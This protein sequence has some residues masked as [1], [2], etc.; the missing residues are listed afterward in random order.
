MT[1]SIH[2]R[3]WLTNI[4]F[5]LLAYHWIGIT[6]VHLVQNQHLVSE[7]LTTNSW[8]LIWRQPSLDNKTKTK[9][10]NQQ[11]W[12][13]I[14][15][16]P[17]KTVSMTKSHCQNIIS[18][19]KTLCPTPNPRVLYKMF[20]DKNYLGCNLKEN[21]KCH[22]RI[23]TLQKNNSKQLNELKEDRNK[24]KNT[25]L[26]ELTSQFKI[27]KLNLVKGRNNETEKLNT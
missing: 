3:P 21:H 19:A 8:Y 16:I 1:H 4:P 14:R 18:K 5:T 10:Y 23:Q 22:Q 6:P 9:T 26:N 27:W 17:N 24:S 12:P 15:H 11:R 13:R 25:W 20:S 7:G 2:L